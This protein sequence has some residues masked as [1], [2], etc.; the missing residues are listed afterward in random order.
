MF[1]TAFSD[2]FVSQRAM[3]ILRE[4]VEGCRPQCVVMSPAHSRLLD[5]AVEYHANRQFIESCWKPEGFDNYSRSTQRLPMVVRVQVRRDGAFGSRMAVRDDY[6][7]TR[8][9]VAEVCKRSCSRAANSRS[10]P[11]QRQAGNCRVGGSS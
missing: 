10:T 7:T 11:N 2:D 6:A 5:L 4:H 8:D 3:L 1:V 9:E